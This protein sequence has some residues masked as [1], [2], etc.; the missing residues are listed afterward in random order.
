ML[1]V[2]MAIWGLIIGLVLGVSLAVLNVLP[3]SLTPAYDQITFGLVPILINSINNTF[4]TIAGLGGALSLIIGLPATIFIIAFIDTAI[5]VLIYNH[6]GARAAYFQL[7]FER[8]FKNKFQL[9]S[10][11]VGPI[12]LV[13]GVI[14]GVLG[15]LIVSISFLGLIDLVNVASAW[16]II[17][18][19]LSRNDLLIYLIP[20]IL[21]AALIAIFYNFLASKF[22]G[23]KLKLD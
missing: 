16:K 3:S 22:G 2:I 9:K 17:G 13:T 15:L 7:N 23:I 10:I 8:D 19:V 6:I 14:S 12:T 5:I 1:S 18:I 21:I 11:P 4:P 20:N